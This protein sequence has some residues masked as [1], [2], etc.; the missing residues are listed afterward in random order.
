[1]CILGVGVGGVHQQMSPAGV[2]KVT[3]TSS[4]LL[5]F[6]RERVAF[7]KKILKQQRQRQW[8]S[9]VESTEYRLN[10]IAI[11]PYSGSSHV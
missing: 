3:A 11:W 2:P 5:H 9:V 8:G 4:P 6:P 7:S 10:D 1:M